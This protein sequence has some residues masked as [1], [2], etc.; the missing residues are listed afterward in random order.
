MHYCRRNAAKSPYICI[1]IYIYISDSPPRMG[2]IFH[3]HCLIS[4]Q[5]ITL[6]S[7][8]WPMGPDCLMTSTFHPQ[9]HPWLRPQGE[10]TESQSHHIF[11]RKHM[12][13]KQL[14]VGMHL[15]KLHPGAN[16]IHLYPNDDTSPTLKQKNPVISEDA[17]S[18]TFEFDVR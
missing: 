17:A 4:S 9:K 1:I 18:K 13:L 12:K 11:W 2:S 5:F 7:L 6:V 14:W 3:D 15:K 16:N 8:S 10:D